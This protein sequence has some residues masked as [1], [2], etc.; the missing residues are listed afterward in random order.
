MKRLL[1]IF[2]FI[3]YVAN[4]IVVGDDYG[5]VYTEPSTSCPGPYQQV[6]ESG[7]IIAETTSVGTAE[8][9][10]KTSPDASCM[11]FAPADEKWSDTTGTY[12]FLDACAMTE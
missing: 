11:M 8:T 12:Q 6:S 5:K 7:I 2:I 4:A 3:P 1:L 9:C 10:L